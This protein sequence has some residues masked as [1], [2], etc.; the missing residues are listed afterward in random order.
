[1][2]FTGFLGQQQKNLTTRSKSRYLA[3]W[4]AP[5]SLL[6]FI[7]EVVMAS[8]LVNSTTVVVNPAFLQEIKDSNPDLWQTVHQL[9]Q[10]CECD[11]EP[12]KVCRQLTR[13]LDNLRGQISLQFTLEESYGYMAIPSSSSNSRPL[14]ELAAKAQS[15]HGVLYLQL[16]ELAEQAEELQYRGV[17]LEQLQR[18]VASTQRFDA[19]LREH[20]QIESELID[21][22]FHLS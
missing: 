17:E 21:R 3:V 12:V 19:Q 6:L 11:E 8:V 5:T 4:L 1:M 2:F 16:T 7:T 13:L 9:R 22:S 14:A 15:Q 18:L 10:A 20:E